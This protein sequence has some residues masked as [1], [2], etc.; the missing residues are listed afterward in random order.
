MSRDSQ[1]YYLYG[2]PAGSQSIGGMLARAVALV[3]GVI[4]F[5]VAVFLGAIFLAALVGFMIIVAGGVMA[6]AWWL[7]RQALQQA[8][9]TGDLD[10]EYT[11]VY[12]EEVRR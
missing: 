3:G 4:G 12:E 11:V 6:R 10:A 5:G 2:R 1:A 9:E 8:S 7:R